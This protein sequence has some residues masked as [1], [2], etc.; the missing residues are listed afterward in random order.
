MDAET[1]ATVRT[2]LLEQ[3]LNKLVQAQARV[4][5]WFDVPVSI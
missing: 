2:S 3:E 5:S 1:L 4:G